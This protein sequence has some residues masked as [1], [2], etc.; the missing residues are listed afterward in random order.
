MRRRD[1]SGERFGHAQFGLVDRAV[2]LLVRQLVAQDQLEDDVVHRP[3]RA[4]L[5]QRSAQLGDVLARNLNA[6]RFAPGQLAA[7][8]HS[9]TPQ[10]MRDAVSDGLNRRIPSWKSRAARARVRLHRVADV[11]DARIF[12]R[13]RQFQVAGHDP[14]IRQDQLAQL[15]PIYLEA[16]VRQ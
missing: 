3:E 9:N 13:V 14:I 5:S 16:A 2:A 1:R 12:P 10:P 8:G 4:Q 15:L 6:A 11:D 7:G